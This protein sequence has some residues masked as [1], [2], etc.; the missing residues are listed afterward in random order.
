[1][2][3]VPEVMVACHMKIHVL[4]LSGISNVAIDNLDVDEAAN[5][6]EVLMAGRTL[7]PRLGSRSCAASSAALPVA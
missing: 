7:V 3:T 6:E 5:H 1:M 2:S 4:G